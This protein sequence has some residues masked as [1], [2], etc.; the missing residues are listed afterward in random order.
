MN[1]RRKYIVRAFCQG[2]RAGLKD[3]S[4]IS[5]PAMTGANC[6]PCPYKW[7]TIHYIKWICGMYRGFH[8]AQLKRAAILKQARKFKK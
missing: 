5:D 2:F 8:K 1:L 7:G 4:K 3:D 6:I